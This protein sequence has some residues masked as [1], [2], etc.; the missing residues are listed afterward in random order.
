MAMDDPLRQ[1]T[2]FVRA[3]IT[4]GEDVII[5]G[6]KYGDIALVGFHYTSAQFWNLFDLTY[7]NPIA[8]MITFT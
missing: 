6:T 8:E 4:Q 2:I 5:G 1:R 3:L 7:F